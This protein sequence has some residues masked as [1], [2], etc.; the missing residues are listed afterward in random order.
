MTSLD[1][2]LAPIYIA[3]IYMLAY[4]FRNKHY[5][6]GHP[7]REYFI[8]GLTVK[9]I[10]AISAGLIYFFYYHYGDTIYYYARTRVIY[11]AFNIDF[12]TGLRLVFASTTDFYYT[13]LSPYIEP[14]RAYDASSYMVLR[15]SGPI[16]ILCGNCYSCIAVIFAYISFRGIWAL[17]VTFAEQY[18]TQLRQVAL[19]CLFIPS[20]FFW[21]SGLFKDTITMACVGWMTYGLYKVFFKREKILIN[22]IILVASFYVT[23]ATKAYIALCFAPAAMFWIFLTYNKNIKNKALRVMI[24]PIILVIA[25]GAGYLF[26]NQ[27]GQQNAFWSVDSIAERAEDMQWWHQKVGD[28]YG[29]EGGAGSMYTIGDGSFTPGNL[30][31]SFPQAINVTLFRP[32]LWEVRNPVMLMAAIESLIIFIFTIRTIFRAGLG[33][34]IKISI[35]NP[36]IFFCLLFSVT[37]AFAVGFTSFNFGALVRYKIPLMPFY[38]LGIALLEYH[39]KKE[40]NLLPLEA[41]E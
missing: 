10:G 21:G 6:K 38:Y 37:F 17:F 14:L 29:E 7:Y 36:L 34:S 3:I 5:P 26:I 18:P 12:M 4:R 15:F 24:T 40:R 41:T 39:S 9:I 28:L 2:F 25:A 19:A 35:S 1:L 20:V 32:Y 23:F 33:R 30:L 31:V 16:S 22:S 27:L 13:D 8:P 11:Q